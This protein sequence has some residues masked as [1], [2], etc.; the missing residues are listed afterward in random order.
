M[1]AVLRPAIRRGLQ[2]LQERHTTARTQAARNITHQLR[3]TIATQHLRAGRHQHLII[4]L[5]LP[6]QPQL[7][8]Q[9]IQ[10]VEAST[11]TNSVFRQN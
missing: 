3:R 5:L 11:I 4:P 8:T 7:P 2:T 1:E 9:S 10:V 6:I